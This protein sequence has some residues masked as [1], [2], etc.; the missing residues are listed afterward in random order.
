MYYYATSLI[1]E[2]IDL[3]PDQIVVF[4]G[5]HN[6]AIIGSIPNINRIRTIMIR[7]PEDICNFKNLFDIL[8]CPA[9][10]GGVTMVD[11]LMVHTIPDI[12]EVF[13][14]DFFSESDLEARKRWHPFSA[15]ASSLLLTISNY[16]KLT[17]MEHFGVSDKVVNVTYLSA[18]DI[19]HDESAAGRMPA[20]MPLLRDKFLFF[21]SSV[22]RHKNHTLIL[23]A[24]RIIRD[25]QGLEISA[26]FTGNLLAGDFN[27]IDIFSEIEKRNL[28]NQVFHLEE[29]SLEELKFL[30]S[31]A[32]AL[33]HP[34]L[35]EGFG[36]PI[37][38]AMAAGCPVIAANVASLP[39]IAQDAAVY[40][41]PTDAHDLAR[42][43]LQFLE[44]QELVQ[45][46]V[47][48][49]KR[50]A[51]NYSDRITAQATLQ[52]FYE[53]Y[54]QWE[55]KPKTSLRGRKKLFSYFGLQRVWDSVLKLTPWGDTS[56]QTTIPTST[57]DSPKAPSK[58]VE[59]RD[60]EKSCIGPGNYEVEI[61]TVRPVISVITP[62]FNQ[63]RFI[64]RT[65]RS[66]F[67][68]RGDFDIEYFIADGG[69]TDETISILQAFESD[70]KNEFNENSDPKIEF[71]WV[72]EAD[73]GQADAVNKG[74]SK[75]HGEI[76]AWINSDDVYYPGAFQAVAQFFRENPQVDVV[77]GLCRHIDENDNIIEQY[78]TEPW[79]YA[80]LLET[81]FICQ[82]GVFFRRMLIDLHGALDASLRYCMDYELW[83]RLGKA[84][85]FHYLKCL[86]AGSRMYET[87]KT[88]AQSVAVHY[89][90][91][92][93]F[94]E[95]FG[96]VPRR[97]IYNFAGVFAQEEN[98][99]LDKIQV[100]VDR[101]R[102]LAQD[103]FLKWWGWIPRLE[104]KYMDRWFSAPSR[105]SWK[106][107]RQLKGLD[108]LRIGFDV[109]QTF[110]GTADCGYVAE[111]T[112]KTM[113]RNFP[114]KEYLLYTTFGQVFSDL[115]RANTIPRLEKP[116]IF[117]PLS[118]CDDNEVREFWNVL[119]KHVFETLGCPD[120]IH[121]NNFFCP[122]IIGPRIIFTL[123]DFSFLDHPEFTTTE[124]IEVCRKGVDDA[125]RYADMIVSISN[126]SRD[127]FLNYF[128]DFPESRIKTVYLGNR[129]EQHSTPI[130]VN[131]LTPGN[132]WLSVCTLEPRKNL[133]GLLKA[134]QSYKHTV[135]KVPSLVLAGAQGWLE[136]DLPDYIDSLNMKDF[137][138]VL[139]YVEDS[140]L[141]WLYENC[142]AFCYPSL[143]EGFGLP[144]LEA[145]S[146]GAPVMASNAAG[147]PEVGGDAALYFHPRDVDEIA[148][149]FEK[150][151]DDTDLR[152]HLKIK[153]LEQA[154]KFSW[155]NTVRQVM[156]LYLETLR[157]PPRNS[158]LKT[159]Q[160]DRFELNINQ[161]ASAD[162]EKSASAL[163]MSPYY[164]KRINDRVSLGRKVE[165]WVR[166]ALNR[167]PTLKKKLKTVSV[168]NRILETLWRS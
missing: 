148:K 150:L 165:Y 50:L 105:N 106:L 83:L 122:S 108:R 168:V 94:R 63:G 77:Y 58:M 64:E 66:V 24:V 96:E 78:P 32:L 38:E 75:T 103:A 5:R 69:S 34:S 45:Q 56:E 20:N 87:N 117:Y 156:D 82:P 123:Y 120:I 79:D 30:Y 154:R 145:M 62:S 151:H 52:F 127:R 158:V 155:Q 36:I 91:N 59:E 143:Y 128:P 54:D 157:L 114:D 72:S 126:F 19:F 9:S 42:T 147:L 55:K 60:F 139:G 6:K 43:I 57:E 68:Q 133:R 113:T 109:S 27:R 111:M 37:V 18:H 140:Q 137:V 119:P 112:I 131:G 97:W 46:R 121:S 93:M 92:D 160:S 84:A 76:I 146:L 86:L 65:I 53:A 13:Y 136:D 40:F 135:K 44:T 98:R 166:M 138:I 110:P 85:R 47:V 159:D 95:K 100:D 81:C 8:F 2:L 12:Q 161:G 102:E 10:W 153:G 29:V 125:A 116:N 16:S 48:I 41:D 104:L 90:I 25:E 115:S 164:M 88:L 31:N 74:I 33:V 167:T 21:P 11:R 132:F 23:E 107:L 101:V 144:V 129:F 163:Q 14:P 124:N 142:L 99:A 15:R 141:Q 39:E 149:S 51:R 67:N 134:Y 118:A 17:I 70:L 28:G 162:E 4:H 35:F 26:I 71:G 1:R 3:V 80:R 7:T 61:E 22:W 73:Q 89:E 49:G 152:T 130:P